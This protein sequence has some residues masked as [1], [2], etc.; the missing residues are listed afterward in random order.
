M[1]SFLQRK[2]NGEMKTKNTNFDSQVGTLI[3]PTV[4]VR[5]DLEFCGTLHVEGR[6]VGNVVAERNQPATIS[7]AEHGRIEGQVRAPVILV[8]GE[9]TGDVFGEERVQLNS[10]AR[11][12]G[13][14]H[15]KIVEMAA[16]AQLTGRLL[17]ADAVLAEQS[18]PGNSHVPKVVDSPAPH[19]SPKAQ[20]EHDQDTDVTESGWSTGSR[21]AS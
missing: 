9:L 5:G 21:S 11:V 20:S 7:V 15:Y 12:V 2:S 6:I 19:T 10:K 8:N 3:G 1:L 17:W 16:G 18:E 4:T 13:D 14:I